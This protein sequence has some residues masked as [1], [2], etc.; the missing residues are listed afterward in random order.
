MVVSDGLE[1]GYFGGSE[2]FQ[3][4]GMNFFLEDFLDVLDGLGVI[5]LEL[6]Y[7][8]ADT[9]ISFVEVVIK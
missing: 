1:E 5:P 6:L 8:I 7:K 9:V 4:D 2:I 3:E